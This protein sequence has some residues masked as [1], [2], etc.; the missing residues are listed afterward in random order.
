MERHHPYV[1]TVA[2][3]KGGVGKT[4]IATNLAVFIKALREDLPVT[5]ASFDNHFSVD[6]MFAIGRHYGKSVAG[7]FGAVPAAELV[8]IG[9]YGVQFMAS[10]RALHPPDN[11]YGHLRKALAGSGL[12]G[13]LVLDTRP[14]LDYFTL[15]ALLASDLVLAPV[16]D[17]PSLVNIASI[18]QTMEDIGA[19]P[20]RL[21]LVPSL[22]DKRLKLRG[23]MG[24]REFLV[25][26]A[27]ERDYQVVDT[28]IAKSPKVE[29]LTTNLSSKVYPVLTHAR[30][31]SV[32]YQFRTLAA[33]ALD[34][35]D[36]CHAPLVQEWALEQARDEEMP[37]VRLKRLVDECPVCGERVDGSEGH[38]FQ[39]LRS[40]RNGFIHTPCLRTL[41]AGTDL[42]TFLPVS[43]LMVVE[44]SANGEIDM[45]DHVQLHLFDG[46]G[47]DIGSEPAHAGGGTPWP[48]FFLASSAREPGELYRDY[49][50]I[51]FQDG[52]PG[53]YLD[54]EGF[55]DFGRLRRRALRA[56]RE[57]EGY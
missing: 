24:V 29:G 12:S 11:D 55:A 34:H 37:R 33:F 48:Q 43:G 52:P 44:R 30:Y 46:D 49:L 4:T 38:F 10:E 41:T 40:R 16:K 36:R 31:T 51:T 17:R 3:E 5:I 18:R 21:W 1:I 25:G 22:I 8:Q 50:T 27:E 20:Q 28:W 14:I 35:Y 39:D 26:Q 23:D 42:G 32:H 45:D 56:I 7:L 47:D 57:R 6:S 19:D 54:R 9:E 2:S 15:N 13:V 53:Q